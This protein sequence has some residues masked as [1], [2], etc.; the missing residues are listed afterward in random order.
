MSVRAI[1]KLTMSDCPPRNNVGAVLD[2]NLYCNSSYFSYFYNIIV[3]LL[4][5]KST[6]VQKATVALF[7]GGSGHHAE[8]TDTGRENGL[9][10]GHPSVR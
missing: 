8:S 4:L 2:G 1:L 5:F 9:G 3:A 7:L 6:V 10:D